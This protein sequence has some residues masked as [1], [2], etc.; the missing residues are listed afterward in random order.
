MARAEL[1]YELKQLLVLLGLPC[2]LHDARAL[3]TA[4]VVV[5]RE[6]RLADAG[7]LLTRRGFIA[8]LLVI[9]DAR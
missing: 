4:V 5:V 3:G 2:T 8:C 7:R 6:H 9:R 1:C